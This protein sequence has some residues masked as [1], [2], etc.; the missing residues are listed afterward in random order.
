MD[1]P[2]QAGAEAAALAHD[3]CADGPFLYPIVYP[4]EHGGGLRGFRAGKS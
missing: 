1:S 2:E 4:P 3:Q